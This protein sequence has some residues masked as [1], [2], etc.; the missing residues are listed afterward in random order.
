MWP[1]QR[2]DGSVYYPEGSDPRTIH[3]YPEVLL[4]ISH[5]VYSVRSLNSLH[6][7]MFLLLHLL[8][9]GGSVPHVVTPRI[10]ELFE[11]MCSFHL[12]LL[13]TIIIY[14]L[15]IWMSTYKLINY[16]LSN[17]NLWQTHAHTIVFKFSNLCLLNST[18]SESNSNT[19]S[20]L[21]WSIFFLEA[22]PHS[23]DFFFDIICF[24]CPNLKYH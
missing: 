12:W 6:V 4:Y 23:S 22:L 18:N 16:S 24:H 20:L 8:I 1:R 13:V 9:F 3:K 2:V 10:F 14:L 15:C 19:K 7:F 5:C 21:L 11:N 17:I